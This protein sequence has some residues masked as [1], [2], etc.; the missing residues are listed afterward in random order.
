MATSHEKYYQF[1]VC[2]FC[3]LNIEFK[4]SIN[5]QSAPGRY[6]CFDYSQNVI[7]L[8]IDA[9][10]GALDRCEYFQS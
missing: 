10:G 7:V 6:V 8:E 9:Y 5:L 2:F 3:F 4:L 1:F